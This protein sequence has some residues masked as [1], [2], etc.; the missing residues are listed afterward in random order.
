MRIKVHMCPR[1]FIT[2]DCRLGNSTLEDNP[3][4]EANDLDDEDCD[5]ECEDLEDDY[6]DDFE[7]EEENDDEEVD[8]GA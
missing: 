5:H 3:E 6:D 4:M 1:C 7:V 8:D 2:C